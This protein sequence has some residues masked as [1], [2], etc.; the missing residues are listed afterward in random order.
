MW[1]TIP[2]DEEVKNFLDHVME[3]DEAPSRKTMEELLDLCAIGDYIEVP[4]RLPELY[5]KMY[6]VCVDTGL[7]DDF[8]SMEE[9]FPGK[10]TKNT[11]LNDMEKL[12]FGLA[13]REFV[14][15]IGLENLD[16]T[17]MSVAKLGDALKNEKH[18]DAEQVLNI[19]RGLYGLQHNYGNEY[20][21]NSLSVYNPV[22]EV[23]EALGNGKDADRFKRELAGG[24][25][26]A[27][28]YVQ[29]RMS[30]L[31]LFLRSGAKTLDDFIP[32]YDP[33][34]YDPEKQP[35]LEDVG[36][37][38][39]EKKI[40]AEKAEFQKNLQAIGD[41][42]PEAEKA[43]KE[44]AAALEAAEKLLKEHTEQISPDER[45]HFIDEVEK[46]QA[47]WNRDL[48]N[49][50]KERTPDAYT[51]ALKDNANYLKA[52]E[53]LAAEHPDP[54]VFGEAHQEKLAEFRKKMESLTVEEN[55]PDY[56]A[57]AAGSYD[58]AVQYLE[59]VTADVQKQVENAAQ[60]LKTALSEFPKE[61]DEIRKELEELQKEDIS[62]GVREEQKD[63]QEELQER[64]AFLAERTKLLQDALAREVEDYNE[65]HSFAHSRLED[66]K[67]AAIDR[68][69]IPMEKSKITDPIDTARRIN[70][71]PLEE[72]LEEMK[73]YFK[74][75]QM[76]INADKNRGEIETI[77]D[78]ISDTKPGFRSK[79]SF[80]RKDDT[81]FQNMKDAVSDYLLNHDAEHAA[82]AYET[83]RK[84][85]NGWM[86]ADQTLKGGTKEEN[87]R[88][89]G[90]VRML[91]LM[92]KMPE[93]QKEIGKTVPEK[94][95]DAEKAANT[96][97][98]QRE[99][100]EV[101]DKSEKA[102]HTKLN[103]S[104][105]ENSLA[106]HSSKKKADRHHAGNAKNE[107]AFRN[108]NRRIDKKKAAEKEAAKKAKG[109]VKKPKAK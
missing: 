59:R 102:V 72:N 2:Q 45:Q 10:H 89:Q 14:S 24:Q 88:N 35:T 33:K 76:E 1:Y 52:F 8:V 69:F 68:Y 77:F 93:F 63:R 5:E 94:Q 103:F 61:Q 37:L 20:Y 90:V 40:E 55:I 65:V 16:E 62:Q 19:E 42:E 87:T 11:F 107:K 108:L 71:L 109:S 82:K 64:Q 31:K 60:E 73:Q 46:R 92:E 53:K 75:V 41:K 100:W 43:R 74:K 91:E 84:Y 30:M 97:A 3:A 6:R 50:I 99:G 105:L 47:Q 32:L 38:V 13:H 26:Q 22:E 44:A 98:L 78:A 48:H 15:Q 36:K 17:V 21:Q 96:E 4:A 34:T 29:N 49:E 54:A 81:A 57:D 12:C 51:Q 9:L 83:C 67:T 79:W 86:K 80:R 18:F 25:L 39:T 58:R 101:V 70:V 95:A 104:Q 28:D 85:L 56:R 66:A 106:K 7:V 27:A 23:E